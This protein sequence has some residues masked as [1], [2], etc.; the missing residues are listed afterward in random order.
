MASSTTGNTVSIVGG[1]NTG[2]I[3]SNAIWGDIVVDPTNNNKYVW[4]QPT[5]AG[6]TPGL[7]KLDSNTS[8]I[9]LVGSSVQQ[10]MESLF[11]DETGGLYSYGAT[12][13]GGTQNIL[14]SINKTTGVLTTVG[15]PDITVTQ[16]DGCNCAYG[17][18]ITL[19]SPVSLNYN[20]CTTNPFNFTYGLT[21]STGAPLTGATVSHTLD[22]R[23]K[24]TATAASI[25]TSLVPV[26]GATPVVTITSSGGGTNNVLT[27][28]GLTI[29][30]G[31]NFFNVAVA[32][33]VGATFTGG[34]T[35]S[36][37]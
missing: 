32:Q 26:F 19:A 9:T 11:F 31:T 13:L 36:Y 12:S 35:I 30:V 28:T 21:N 33:V 10:S 15:T 16:S 25:Q 20:N 17:A 2:D 29:P 4:Y 5:A 22:P 7:Y 14:F 8:L 23:F 6:G 37:T 27:I 18:G 34:E 24:I 1:G 3:A